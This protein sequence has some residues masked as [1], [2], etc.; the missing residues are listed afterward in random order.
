MSQDRERLQTFCG[1]FVSFNANSS[2]HRRVVLPVRAGYQ[3]RRPCG[4]FAQ[5]HAAP[6][7][8]ASSCKQSLHLSSVSSDCLEG[9]FEIHFPNANEK[10]IVTR[11]CPLQVTKMSRTLLQEHDSEVSRN[12]EQLRQVVLGRCILRVS[13]KDLAS[14]QTR[15]IWRNFIQDLHR[16]N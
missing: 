2:G 1:G 3:T 8:R 10:L 16:R 11:L 15:L 13:S 12:V 6:A 7:S 4:E 5:A 9:R 14:Q